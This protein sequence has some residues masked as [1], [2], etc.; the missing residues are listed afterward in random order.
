MDHDLEQRGPVQ[1]WLTHPHHDG[2]AL[3]VSDLT[4]RLG[5]TVTV[6]LRVPSEMPLDHVHA[7]ITPD[8]EQS[9][10][11]AA[12][13]AARSSDLETWWRADLVCHNRVTR[14]RFILAGGPTRYAWLNAT[15][16]HLRDVPDVSDFRL[17]AHD[18]PPPAWA[19]DAVVYQV[20][21]DRF[22]KSAAAARRRTQ[23]DWALPARWSD[24]VVPRDAKQDGIG[25]Q[26][27]GGDLDGIVEHLDHIE[28]LGATTVYLTPFFPGRSNHRYDASTFTAVDPFLGGEEALR[29]LTHAA[30]AR[31]MKV[32][33]DFTTNHTG[34]SHEW[35]V[36][37]RAS[38]TAPEREFYFWETRRR[39]I[40]WLGVRSLP[41]LNYDS[42]AL[43]ERV[44]DDPEGVVRKW[45]GPAANL[46][47]WRVDV[48]NMTGRQGAQDLNHEIAAL[49]RDAVADA[50]PD[51][52]LVGE[53]TND[54]SDDVP[55]DG[56]H[57]V[58]N[59]AGFAKPVWTWLCDPRSAPDFLG[60]PVLVPRLGGEAVVETMRDFASHIS[61][62]ALTHSFNL[63]GSH[64]TTRIRTL[65]GP[66]SRLVDAAAG[67]LLTMPS[68][69]MFTYG[70]EIGME[71]TFG[72]DGRRP[73]PWDRRRWDHRILAAY[74]DLIS[75]RRESTA[76]RHGGLRWVYAADDVIVYLRETAEEVA[77]VHVARGAHAPVSL[78]ARLLPGIAA[79]RT[80]YGQDVVVGPGSITLTA[81][82]PGVGIRIWVPTPHRAPRRSR[83]RRDQ[84]T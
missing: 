29:R 75:V 70:D 26:F 35:F 82:G 13:D 72:E 39:Y 4:P 3:Y 36:A 52:L 56:W 64:D 2:S 57:G 74:R 41:K 30:H 44:F 9:F 65:V 5:D 7:R 68:I 11:K 83:A 78:D 10:V 58:M 63:V 76:L 84:G 50:N 27:Y 80:A 32:M 1:T 20:F 37:A 60:S 66:D 45:L 17:V 21:P 49:M 23:P 15:G 33:G 19:A 31:G 6:W 53:H 34:A 51:A 43:R 55:G 12:V 62:L 28:E 69:P 38:L 67:L 73:M 25:R 14:Y 81:Q 24:P 47:G 22:A 46:D 61:W 48:A 77:L 42:T 71:G 79:G 40:A 54:Y 18:A 8:A 16:L 59:Y